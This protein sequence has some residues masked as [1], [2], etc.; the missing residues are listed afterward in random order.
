V[1]AYSQDGGTR[2]GA[3]WPAQSFGSCCGSISEASSPVTGDS[4]Q[5]LDPAPTSAPT[6]YGHVTAQVPALS[7]ACPSPQAP[8][9]INTQDTHP[10][11]CAALA[12]ASAP[13]SSSVPVPDPAPGQT[14][15]LSKPLVQ[16]S[17][18]MVFGSSTATDLH[19]ALAP[20]RTRS[21]AGISKPKIFSNGMVRY[22]YTTAS[23]EPYTVK[24]ALSSPSWK[25][26]MIDEYNALL[27]NKTWTFV[28]SVFGCNM[29]DCK[30]VLKLKYRAYGSVDHHKARLAAK[31]FK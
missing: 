21:Q 28:P 25:V 20:R 13:D 6:N 22:A 9:C 8:S 11:S 26:M 7:P 31:G 10:T 17:L 15:R 4:N 29:I 2:L 14:A 27:R 23:W 3:W 5:A 18:T 1:C 12:I 24:E 19:L 30:W 16:S